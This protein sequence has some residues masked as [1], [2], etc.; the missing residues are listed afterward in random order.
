MSH[1]RLAPSDSKR[2]SSCTRAISFVEE[3]ADRLPPPKDT[4]ESSDGT[5]AHDWASKIL[6]GK[7]TIED[8]Q[9]PEWRDPIQVYLDECDKLRGHA[10]VYVESEVPLFYMPGKIGTVDFAAVTMDALYINDLKFGE[11]VLVNAEGNT[12]LAIYAYSLICDLDGIYAFE[13][14]NKV[15]IRIIQPRYSGDEKVKLWEL[16]VGELRTFCDHIEAQAIVVLRH[17]E[18]QVFAPSEGDSGACRWCRAKAIC[19]ARH[20]AMQAG[21]LNEFEVIEEVECPSALTVETA[22]FE[23]LTGQVPHV[24]TEEQ[25]TT[26]FKNA[27]AIRSLLKHVEDYALEMANAGRALPGTKLVQGNKRNAEWKDEKAAIA[28]L[29][30]SGFK[31]VDYMKEKFVSPAQVRKLVK[32]KSTRLQNRIESLITRGDGPQIITTEDDKRPAVQPAVAEFDVITESEEEGGADA[33]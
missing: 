29:K 14:S 15:F 23:A 19:Q 9:P 3:N 1:A 18:Q 27:D 30:N 2:W 28:A 21:V 20:D 6:T 12:Q 16:T 5:K 22:Q 31:Q 7:C 33:V 11:G 10:D 4:K 25:V 17:P 13:D 8:V 24:L 32:D 26:L